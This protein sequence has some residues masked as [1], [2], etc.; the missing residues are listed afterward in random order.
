M[1]EIIEYLAR[2]RATKREGQ[3]YY[4]NYYL[5]IVDEVGVYEALNIEGPSIDPKTMQEEDAVF[6]DMKVDFA[7]DNNID[8]VLEAFY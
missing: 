1:Y 4:M 2:R 8:I 7:P 5:S 3:L 6:K